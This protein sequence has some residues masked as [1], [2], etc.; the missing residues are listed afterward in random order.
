MGFSSLKGVS[1]N[2]PARANCRACRC[3][4][5]LPDGG[6]R[7]IGAV[8]T[9]LIGPVVVL[10]GFGLYVASNVWLGRFRRLP[11]EFIGLSTAGAL[12]AGARALLVPSTQATVA[13][14]LSLVLL[15]GLCWLYFWY[16][17]YGEREDRPRVGDAFPA[18]RLPA[19]D[20]S[21]YVFSGTDRQR[22]L[23]I[24]YRGS[25]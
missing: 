9:E 20:G 2:I 21:L 3:G 22:R 6:R 4:T 13:A 11:Y 24:F 10:S 19:S 14:A 12:Y 1:R 23:L 8:V 16:S 7:G 18:F 15:G 17:M 5:P 25:W